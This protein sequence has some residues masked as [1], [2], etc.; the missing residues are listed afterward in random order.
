VTEFK[1]AAEI[2]EGLNC[3]TWV[4]EY[5]SNSETRELSRVDQARLDKMDKA[6]QG[7]ASEKIH[8][9]VQ[10]HEDDPMHLP[11][12]HSQ[13]SK[14]RPVTHFENKLDNHKEEIEVKGHGGHV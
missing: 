9:W 5:I 14:C 1:G 11:R 13:R 3:Q 2:M 10:H 12:Y 8:P 7:R 6:G 4:C